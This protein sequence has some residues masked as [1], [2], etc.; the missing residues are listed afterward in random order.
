MEKDR[1]ELFNQKIVSAQKSIQRIKGKHM[2]K[3]GLAST[4]TICLRLLYDNPCGLTK[5]EIS[6]NC[7]MD[8]SQIS[9]IVS[10]L[11]G[12]GYAISDNTGKTYNHRFFLTDEGRRITEEINFIVLKVNSFVSDS[13]SEEDIEKF[14]SVFETINQGLRSAEDKF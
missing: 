7:D 9:R 3:Y 12:K 11:T 14:Y 5:K 8:K 13:I 10:E 6:D 2:E 4:H 1:F